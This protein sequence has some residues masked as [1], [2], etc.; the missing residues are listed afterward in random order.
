MENSRS[1]IK[2]RLEVCY[3]HTPRCKCGPRSAKGRR[4]C[5]S[6]V[7]YQCESP[8]AISDRSRGGRAMAGGMSRYSTAARPSGGR[9]SKGETPTGEF[10]TGST[11]S[12]SSRRVRKLVEKCCS[13][14]RHLT[15]ST[16]GPSN[17]ECKC[18]NA[19]QQCTGCYCWGKC[20]NKGQLMPPPTTMRGL[21]GPF[22]QGADPPTTDPCATTLPV[23]FPT[24]SSLREIS[25]AR[26]GGR[27][28][29]AL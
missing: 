27:R 3:T 10:G 5:A 8:S 11:V 26:D 22:P 6:G 7:S 18:R 12:R 4:L 21:L 20:K 15:C 9:K 17:R 24:S 19:G 2:I 14:T 16:T 13:C 25:A 1:S 28:V 29:R 23:R